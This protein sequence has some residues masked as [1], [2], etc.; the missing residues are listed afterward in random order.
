MDRFTDNDL[1]HGYSL[2]MARIY[3]DDIVPYQEDREEEDSLP[4]LEPITVKVVLPDIPEWKV[5]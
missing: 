4:V 3:G 2:H 5:A 1:A